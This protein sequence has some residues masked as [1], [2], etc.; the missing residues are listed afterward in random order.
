[1]FKQYKNTPYDI[2]DDGRCYS[3]LSNKFLTPK[4]SIAYPTYNLTINGK[5]HQVKIH[6]M[7]AETFIKNDENK[8][9][10]NH[11]DGD[12]H[13]YHVSNLEWVTSKEN[14]QHAINTGLRKNGDQSINKFIGNLPN[15]E[16]KT[17]NNYPNYIVSSIGRVMNINT[18]R[19]LKSYIDNTG[20]LC[21]NLWKNNKGKI[22][23]IHKLVY[24]IFNNDN[25]LNGYV[26]DHIDGNKLNNNISNLEK[27]TYQENNLR[28]VYST[29]KNNSNKSVIQLDDNRQKIAEFASIA[30]AQRKLDI[31]N[32]SRAIKKQG[33]AGGFYWIFKE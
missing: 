23:R 16:W 14:S 1:M 26:I 17:Y 30:E 7:V 27:V 21:V 32:I 25:D 6:R 3:H 31:S 29:G 12:T 4:M 28:A 19:L 24:C 11:I 33:H 22:H 8:P 20:Y 9:I 10:V 2:Y 13:N 18:K 15:E 5:K